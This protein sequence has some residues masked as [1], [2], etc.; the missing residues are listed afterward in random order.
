MLAL[1]AENCE[2]GLSFCAIYT[3]LFFRYSLVFVQFNY[4][5]DFIQY[6]LIYY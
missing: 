4:F 3:V 2:H 6:F 5:Y 1:R